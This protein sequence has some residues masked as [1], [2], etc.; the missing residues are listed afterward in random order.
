MNWERARHLLRLGRSQADPRSAGAAVALPCDRPSVRLPSSLCVVSGKGGTGKTLVLA[1]LAREL[2]T[3]GPTLVLDADLGCANAHL[4]HDVHSERSLIDVIEGRLAVRDVV[5]SCGGDLALLPGGSGFARLAGLTDYE[6]M[7]L[8]RGLEEVEPSFR[9]L[10]V[11][12]AAGLSKQTIAFALACDVVLLVTTPDVTAMTDAYAFLKVFVR[13]SPRAMPWL[14]VNRCAEIGEAE[15]VARR[16]SDVTRKFLG[17]DLR[18]IAALPEDRAAFRC[19][20]HRTPVTIGEPHSPLAA[21]LRALA[22]SAQELLADT[23][24]H[25]V[26]A[27]LERAL[28]LG[29]REH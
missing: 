13:Q 15:H 12:S 18:C 20:Q 7:V 25:G 3:R 23:P 10:C 8:A 22:R 29:G 6:L 26:G 2:S 19:T 21:S 5:L 4:L 28:R 14:V 1:A 11:D 17:R 9:Y 16:V 27:T 24:A